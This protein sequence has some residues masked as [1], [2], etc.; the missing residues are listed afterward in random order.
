LDP[1]WSADWPHARSSAT[2]NHG[3]DKG[4]DISIDTCLSSCEET[5]TNEERDTRE[6]REGTC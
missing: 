2:G 4:R 5:R 1:G 3:R 6:G